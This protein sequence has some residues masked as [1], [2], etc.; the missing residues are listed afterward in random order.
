MM[1]MMMIQSFSFSDHHLVTCR[2]G[3]PPSP[4]GTT[5]YSY[6]P[7]RNVDVAAFSRDILSSRLYDSTVTDA[8]DYTPNCSTRKSVA[9]STSMHHCAPI[10]V[11]VDSMKFASC[12]MK[13]AKPSKCWFREKLQTRQKYSQSLQNTIVTV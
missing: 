4:P 1:M 10:V 7:L 12:P 11:V 8:D 5:T 9:F 13:H 6:R 2:L 3:V